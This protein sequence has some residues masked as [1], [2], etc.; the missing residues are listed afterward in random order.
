MTSFQ[1][2][3]VELRTTEDA[4]S[5]E[6]VS[7]QLW[8]LTVVHV[9]LDMLMILIILVELAYVSKELLS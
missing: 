2:I 5:L 1:Q 6:S 7:L 8:M 4:L 9:C 3:N